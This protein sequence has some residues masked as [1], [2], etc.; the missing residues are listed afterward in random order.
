MNDKIPIKEHRDGNQQI[1]EVKRKAARA[2]MGSARTIMS[3]FLIFTATVVMTTDISL[4]SLASIAP[5]GLQFFVLIFVSYGMYVNEAGG[6]TQKGLASEVY[7]AA[8]DRF[9]H[10]KQRINEL[11]LQGR[12]SEFCTAYI[13]REL[14][15]TRTAILAEAGIS[16]E[17]YER[18]YLGKD[19]KTLKL[20]DAELAAVQSA[21]RTK[22]I[23]LTPDMLLKRGRGSNKRAPLGVKPETKKYV[24]F[25]SK[26]A[27]IALTS[28]IMVMIAFDVMATVNWSTVAAVALKIL[29]VVLNGF[30]G[31]QFGYENITID[32][33]NYMNDQSDLMEQAIQ[34]CEANPVKEDEKK[35]A[36][37]SDSQV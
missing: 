2:V 11:R 9:D 10:L 8:R 36:A 34:Y 15:A 19:V 16:Y 21:S 1:S 35:R 5:L 7:I 14:E 37:Y 29:A 12:L 25:G 33:V 32:T 13:K 17:K 23:K 27:T 20:S 24:A 22:P 6:G 26:F 3:A 4:Q 18:E 28:L 30:A 31:Y